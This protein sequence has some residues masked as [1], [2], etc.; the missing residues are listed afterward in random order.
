[1]IFSSKIYYLAPQ[2]KK[3]GACGAPNFPK[4]LFNTSF[5]LNTPQKHLKYPQKL[6]PA[7]RSFIR[8]APFYRSDPNRGYSYKGGILNWNT[9]DH[10][11]KF[12]FNFRRFEY[13]QLIKTAHF[14]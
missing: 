7:A 1:M 5:A 12:P 9:I 8:I 10:K 4:T 2:A 14:P 3:L 11:M 6:S 13:F